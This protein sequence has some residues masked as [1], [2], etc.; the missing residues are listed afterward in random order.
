MTAVKIAGAAFIICGRLGFG[1]AE[2][3]GLNRRVRL[4]SGL[5]SALE[6]MRGE[7]INRLTPMSDILEL[8]KRE[9]S[10]PVRDFFSSVLLGMENL[11]EKSF[12]EIWSRA[13]RSSGLDLTEPE[14]R[15]LRELGASLGRY[16]VQLQAAALQ[17][18][19]ARFELFLRE[20]EERRKRDGKIHALFPIAAGVSVILILI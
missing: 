9:T 10:G 3:A 19:A 1:A 20:A 11:G 2:I 7:L 5:I 18:T 8:I 4:L 16:D 17:R 14:E 13:V 12:S 6:L 15:A